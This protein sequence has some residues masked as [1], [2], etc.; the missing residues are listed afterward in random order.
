MCTVT[1]KKK[2]EKK[3]PEPGLEL[4]IHKIKSPREKEEIMKMI[5]PPHLKKFKKKLSLMKDFFLLF[6]F[7]VCVLRIMLCM[8]G[9]AK[10]VC[11]AFED[12]N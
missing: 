12:G 3:N 11:F 4:Q 9:N 5:S 2:K 8:Y 6:D 1:K 10:N 7:Y